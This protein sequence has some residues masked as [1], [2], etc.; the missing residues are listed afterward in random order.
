MGV[1]PNINMNDTSKKQV[2]FQQEITNLET[3]I[4]AIESNRTLLGDLVSDTALDLLRERLATLIQPETA[5]DERKRVTVLF[6]D[7]SGYTALSENLDPEDV[8]NIMNRLFEAVTVE[9][10]R[11]GGTIDKYAG[12]AVM[13]LFGAPQAL[14]N[15]EEMAVRASLA[16]QRVIK[17]FS[18]QLNEERGFQL[19]MRIGLNTGEVLAGLVGGLRARSYTVMGD[20][21]NLSARL[22]S[23]APVGGILASEFTT[24]KLHEVFELSPPEKISVKGKSNE[25]TVYKILGEKAQ[26]GRMRG[27][28]GL[29][30]PMIGREA[31]LASLQETFTQLVQEGRWQATAV[32][33]DAGL[34]KSRLQNEFIIWLLE[35]QPNTRILMSRCF[36]HTRTTPYHFIAEIMR[37]LFNLSR[38]A[39]TDTAVHHLTASLE[40]L[41][42]DITNIELQYQLGSLA[43]ILGFHMEHNPIQNLEPEQRRDRTFLSLERIFLAT[44]NMKPLL[45]MIDDMHWADAL[46]LD[47]LDR[48]LKLINQEELSTG[49]AMWLILSRRAENQESTLNKLLATLTE[50]PHKTISITALATAQ[51]EALIEN[52]LDQTIPIELQNLIVEHAQ[53]N[54]FY[55]EEVIRSLIEDGTLKKN[56]KWK[57]T[58]NVADIRIPPSVQD[59]LAARIDRLPPTDKRITQ[60][61]SIIGRIF[62]QHILNKIIQADSVEPTLLL[63]EMR[64]LAARMEESQITEDWEWVFHHGLIQEVAYNSVPKSLRRVIHQQVA[65]LLESQLGEHNS[66]LLPLIADHYEWGQIPDK[67]IE[68]LSRAA[69]QAAAQFANKDAIS[70]YTRAISLIDKKED[71]ADDEALYMLL[72]GRVSIYHLTAE[73]ESQL[74]DLLRLDELANT[75]DNNHFRAQVALHY[76]KY[77]DGNSD[78]PAV[79]QKA[80]N[81]VDWARA[82]SN[83]KLVV[84][85]ITVWALGLLRQGELDEAGQLALDAQKLAQQDK[86]R[87]GE[88]VSLA[89]LGIV[90]YFQGKLKEARDALEQSLQL[91]QLG[92]DLHRQTS[93]LTNLV[94]IYHGLG[95]FAQAKRRCEEALEIAQ[96]IGDRAKAITIVNNLGGMH[97]A[98][99]NLQAARTHHEEAYRLSQLLNNRLGESMAANN[100]GLVLHDLGFVDLAR[101]YATHALTID[102]EIGDRRGEG[103][104]LTA[105]ALALEGAKEYDAAKDAHQKALDL[106]KEI[107]QEACAIDNLAGLASVALQRGDIDT[108]V[109]Q[110]TDVLDWIN[111]NGVDG[112][113]YPI[114]VYLTSASVLRAANDSKKSNKILHIAHTLLQEQASHISDKTDRAAFLHNVPLHQQLHAQLAQI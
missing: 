108:A 34:G 7:V 110:T 104:S 32:T 27:V 80:A 12:D 109:S 92:N 74:A 22:E 33:G 1:N 91:A 84:E 42:P 9:I 63:L 46:S 78:F 35:K 25:I 62:W 2:A 68:Y 14:E 100:L 3:T 60:H 43:S 58:Q 57:V 39:D 79:V 18:Q 90:Y 20:T 70:Y 105:L 48:M 83:E 52:L 106:R 69:D 4:A 31:E 95:D 82:A 94:G 101:N 19:Q 23:A 40:V 114:R 64:Q 37:S 59:I 13:A 50:A 98:L 103:Y 49:S 77:N 76:A 111:E 112:I 66:F 75:L 29:H 38:E 93:C 51:A 5:S 99:G 88:S 36:H 87:Q 89:H 41:E 53:G 55:V 81:A 28:S 21:V 16:M 85:G 67:A 17:E 24:R 6:A 45:I 15:H 30:A 61:A 86:N 44:A 47:F 102:R 26:R 96:M 73:R 56:G 71:T 10:H 8:A 65:D 107:G 97:H 54:P 72:N 11:Y 113:E